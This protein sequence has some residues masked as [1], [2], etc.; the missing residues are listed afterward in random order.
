MI[1][2]IVKPLIERT[3]GG[4]YLEELSRSYEVHQ[5][6]TLPITKYENDFKRVFQEIKPS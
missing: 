5:C 2:L 3:T 4:F 1:F 6:F